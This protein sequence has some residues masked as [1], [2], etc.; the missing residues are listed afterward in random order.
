[1]GLIDTMLLDDRARF[2]LNF[3][4]GGPSVEPGALEQESVSVDQALRIRFRVV[5]I[6]VHHTVSINDR[7]TL[8]SQRGSSGAQGPGQ[9]RQPDCNDKTASD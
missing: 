6:D 2:Q 8:R 9:R 3:S 7:P 4:N 5:W 1:V